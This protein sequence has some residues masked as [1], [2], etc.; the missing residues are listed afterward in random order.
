M[1]LLDLA[2]KIGV[3][4]QA[5]DKIENITSGAIAKATV[6]GNVMYD[7]MK[8]GIGAVTDGIQTIVGGAVEGYRSYEQL[9]GGVEKIFDDAD[10]SQIMRDAQGAFLDLNMSANDYLAAINQTGATFAQ[11]MG[12]QKGYETARTGMKAIADYASGTGRSVDELNEKFAMIT[13]ATSSYQSIADQFSGILPAT[14]KD[15]LDQAKAAGFLTGEYES[16][17][18]VPV[19]QYQEAVSKM[20]E[21]GVKDMGLYNNTMHESMQTIDGSMNMVKSAW[22]NLITAFGTGDQALIY[23]GVT[24]LVN[25]IFGKVNEET[26]KQEGGLIAN[27]L[28][29]VQNVFSAIGENFPDIATKLVQGFTTAFGEAFGLDPS[30]TQDIAT[31]FTELIGNITQSIQGFAEGFSST[32]DGESLGGVFEHLLG[33]MGDFFKFLSDNSEPIGAALGIVADVLLKIAEVVTAVGD[34]LGPFLPAILGALAAIKGFSVLG[35]IVGL[36]TQVGGAIT[37]LTTIIT[38]FGGPLATVA[39]AL[40]GWPLLIAAVVGAIVG[41]IATNKEVREAI[42]N[43]WNEV[44]G[45]F[46]SLP[47][48]FAALW[49]TVKSTTQEKWNSIVE[50]VSGIPQRVKDTLGDLKDTLVEAGKS[51]IT[52]LLDGMKQKAEEMFSWVSGIADRISNL[53]GPLPYDRRVLVSNGQALM[54]GLRGGLQT[55]FERSVMPYVSSMADAMQG[56]L[57]TTATMTVPVSYET[58][59]MTMQSTATVTQDRRVYDA[60]QQ[61]LDAIPNAVY[62]NGDALVGQLARP[63]NAA[64]GGF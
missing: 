10:I 17:T 14:S 45:F 1:N 41:F 64:M 33:I 21:K 12:D 16:L 4:D 37:S 3:D 57:D 7:A 18:D 32:F 20:L 5:S 39:A 46:Q 56:A 22:Q 58:E 44:V 43:V 48:K 13:R 61:I 60:L 27:V 24:G 30:W 55:G 54:S 62:L 29:V 11:T 59:P 36:F 40:G 6:L 31:K 19:A 34:A 35:S 8:T 53:K 63:M 51:I 25:G 15:F 50:W 52:G 42:V 38:T 49:E 47:A 9:A 23:N 28:P 2:V 26:G